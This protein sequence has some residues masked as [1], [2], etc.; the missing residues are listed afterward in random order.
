MAPAASHPRRLWHIKNLAVMIWGTDVL[1][2]RRPQ[3]LPQKR[4]MQSWPPLRPQT[5]HQSEVSPV[6]ETSGTEVLPSDTVRNISVQHTW[7]A[8]PVPALPAQEQTDTMTWCWASSHVT[9]QMGSTHKCSSGSFTCERPRRGSQE[10]RRPLAG[11]PGGSLGSGSAGLEGSTRPG[12]EMFKER[13][14]GQRCGIGKG[15]C[16]V[17]R[18]K[19]KARTPAPGVLASIVPG[20]L[21]EMKTSRR[22]P[23]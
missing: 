11:K 4:K 23:D 3:E 17:E 13:Y 10:G 14:S 21:N 19:V 2:N 15:G 22:S 16:C 7:L 5:K 6:L 12:D 20:A 18:V 8:L 1:K 9:G